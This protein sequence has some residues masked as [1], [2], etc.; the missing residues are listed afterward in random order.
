MLLKALR[1]VSFVGNGGFQ[2]TC[3]YSGV[4]GGGAGGAL[5]PPFGF[6][7]SIA[8]QNFG[9]FHIFRAILLNTFF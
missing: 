8:R 6:K 5:V 7:V 1:K 2:K 9:Q 4:G 3:W